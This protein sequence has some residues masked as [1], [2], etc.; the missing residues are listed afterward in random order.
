MMYVPEL[1]FLIIRI[2]LV[3]ICIVHEKLCLNLLRCKRDYFNLK[4]Y[5]SPTQFS[6]PLKTQNVTSCFK[7][8]KEFKALG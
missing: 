8:T 4:L 3:I 2:V 5:Q 1:W 6:C 7:D